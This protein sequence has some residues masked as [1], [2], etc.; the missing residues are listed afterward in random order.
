MNNDEIIKD[1]LSQVS[2]IC[3]KLSN[4]I[5]EK[6]SELDIDKLFYL[7]SDEITV[8]YKLS[9][10]QNKFPWNLVQIKNL[11][12]SD[13]Y[14]IYKS[15]ITCE[16]DFNN[17]ILKKSEK[18]I[19]IKYRIGLKESIV[20]SLEKQEKLYC[21]CRRKECF[22][23]ELIGKFIFNKHAKTKEIIAFIMDGFTKNVMTN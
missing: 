7:L 20:G 13:V 4:I 22:G 9:L 5:F 17:K 11:S 12:Q 18:K 14:K 8:D 2:L 10:D 1:I 3:L 19:K 23:V 16:R 21:Y 6:G 15:I